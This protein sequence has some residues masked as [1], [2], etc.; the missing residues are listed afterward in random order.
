MKNIFLC[1]SLLIVSTSI[2]ANKGIQFEN[3]SLSEAKEKAQKENKL[4]FI[5]Y[6]ADWCGPCK[7]LAKNV[8][9][10]KEVGILFNSNFIN[11]KINADHD[12]FIG[13]TYHAN[14]LPTLLFID[15]DGNLKKKIVGA[16]DKETLLL[17]VNYVLHPETDPLTIKSKEFNEGNRSKEFLFEYVLI[18][19]ENVSDLTTVLEAYMAEYPN[20]DLSDKTDFIFFYLQDEKEQSPE[21]IASFLNQFGLFYADENQKGQAL[22][23][24]V[25][26]YVK[27][28]KQSAEEKNSTLKDQ[29][30]DELTNFAEK[31]SIEELKAAEI[32]TAFNALYDKSSN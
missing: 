28:I 30:I 12:D 20:L 13:T 8:F 21:L 24:L 6:Y 16:V 9:T 29:L 15:K 11:I 32:K 14:S 10:D 2:A 3:L 5:D 26:I 1:L 17:G 27:R 31:H 19:Q 7:W 4:I 23:K 25:N 22:Q 18:L